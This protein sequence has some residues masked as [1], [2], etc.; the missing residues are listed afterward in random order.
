MINTMTIKVELHDEN[1]NIA[2]YHA[3]ESEPSM[4]GSGP[5][6]NFT[7]KVNTLEEWYEALTING[8]D[9]EVEDFRSNTRDDSIAV[10]KAIR[11]D[12]LARQDEAIANAKDAIE[13][14]K[15]G[16]EMGIPKLTLVRAMRER[17]GH[18]IKASIE[19][20]NG[21]TI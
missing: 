13:L 2:A 11:E 15:V 1:Y 14:C 4:T 6:D 17:F 10:A 19:L 9:L 5:Y 7:S 16:K 12:R 20:V 3:G 8:A 21:L 18:G